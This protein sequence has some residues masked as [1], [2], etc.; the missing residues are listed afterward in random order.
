MTDW[1][2]LIDAASKILLAVAVAVP[3]II[4]ALIARAAYRS[5]VAN[6]KR[7]EAQGQKQDAQNEALLAQGGEIH[8][9]GARLEAAVAENTDISTKAFHEAN[10][11]NLKLEK[12]GLA[13]EKAIVENTAVHQKLHDIA[14]A[15]VAAAM[16]AAREAVDDSRRTS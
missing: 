3:G 10:T 8:A 2:P 7:N 4:A 15:A 9:N 5:S 1:N 12:L 13:H 11:V 14:T 6:G 16:A